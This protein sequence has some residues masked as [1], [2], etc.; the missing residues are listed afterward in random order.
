[1]AADPQVERLG[2]I[3]GYKMG[4]LGQIPGVAAAYGPLFGL[5]IV[6]APQGLSSARF[7]L[8]NLEVEIGFVMGKTLEPQDLP[9]S[10]AEV[11]GAVKEVVL[12][13]EICGRRHALADH[14]EYTNLIGLADCSSAGGVVC[15]K[16]FSTSEVTPE[17]LRDVS[18]SCVVNGEER[19]TGHGSNSPFGSPL[20]SLVWCANH[21]NARGMALRSG[22]LVI[23]GATCKCPDFK[24]GD[25]V[26]ALYGELGSIETTILP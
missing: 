2:G 14:P 17:Q 7:H 21:L 16:R 4:G 15:G 10:E 3:A 8:F 18:T 12:S 1:M 5:G 24:V 11:W 20:A 6:D 25:T 26:A 22:E 13:L 23:G 19:V 9:F